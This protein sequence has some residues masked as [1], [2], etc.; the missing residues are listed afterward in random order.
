M[1]EIAF[2]IHLR[3]EIIFTTVQKLML[4]YY[5]VTGLG[6][7]LALFACCAAFAHADKGDV[8]YT[9]FPATA[10]ASDAVAVAECQQACY[11]ELASAVT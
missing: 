10:N 8:I 9:Y 4:R 11:A 3:S 6:T 7:T 2:V 5:F 1:F